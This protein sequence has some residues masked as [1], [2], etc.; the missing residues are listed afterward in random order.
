V[1]AIQHVRKHMLWAEFLEA[2]CG[3]PKPN[4]PE[5]SEIEQALLNYWGKHKT[6]PTANSGSA[7]PYL[8]HDR[9]WNSTIQLIR[10]RYGIPYT[11]IKEKLGLP[12]H[13]CPDMNKETVLKAIMDFAV[14]NERPPSIEDGDASSYLGTPYPVTW[15]EANNLSKRKWGQT[16]KDL[17]SEIGLP[18]K[19]IY[20][21]LGK[22][23]EAITIWHGR[24]KAKPG[25]RSKQQPPGIK[26]KMSWDALS[27]ILSKYHNTTLSNLYIE[28]GLK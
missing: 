17:K 19:G 27:R 3:I 18:K 4:Y 21:S 9:S 12:S 7:L 26:T 16:L 11:E 2:E 28:M 13:G 1:A 25:C 22:A 6:T 23:K 10:G 15:N 24:H 8:G 14:D 20:I 5:L